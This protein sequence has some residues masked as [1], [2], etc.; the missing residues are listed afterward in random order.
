MDMKNGFN[1]Q[2]WNVDYDYVPTLGMEVIKGRNFSKSYGS[3]SSAVLINETTAKVL[4]YDDPIGKKIYTSTSST[5]GINTAYEIVGV[6]KNFHYESL[7]HQVGPLCMRLGN[8]SWAAA[9]K[10]NTKDV[11]G[12]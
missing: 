9:F 7:R 6:V 4:G 5:A 2:V 10:I 11:R 3:D 1:M 8:N 12:W